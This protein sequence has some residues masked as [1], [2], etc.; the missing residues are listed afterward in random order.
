MKFSKKKFSEFSPDKQKKVIVE[1][2]N[3]IERKWDNKER[4]DQL[5]EELLNCIVW[6]E[7]EGWIEE[8]SQLKKAENLDEFLQLTVP[9][10]QEFGR[11]L[12]DQ[13]FLILQKDREKVEGKKLKI[14]VILHDLRSAF[15][16]GS[17]IRTSECLGVEK[18]IFSGYTPDPENRKVQETSMGTHEYI[19]WEKV[20][21]LPEVI[22]D[23][24]M[25]GHKI[26]GL[27]TTTHALDIYNNKISAPAVLILGNEALGISRDVLKLCDGVIKLPTAG[28]KN[29]LNVGVAFA[30]TGYEIF[31]KWNY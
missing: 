25:S 14:T 28:W 31:R 27:E 17:I 23:L 24:K 7:G 2:I 5:L 30:V 10:V 8:I 1:F 4:R 11:E 29:S 16:V 20:A 9:L 15:N 22:R 12:R 6:N 21:S 18:L 13:D 26:Y 19:Q 3:S